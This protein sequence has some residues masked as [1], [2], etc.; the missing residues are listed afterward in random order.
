VAFVLFFI[1]LGIPIIE[2]AL[3]I[4]VGGA[5]GLFPT[6]AI[7]VLTA[8]VGSAMI[9]AQGLRTWMQAR[10]SMDRGE[11]PVRELFD[12]LCIFAAGI[13]LVTPGFFTDA[14]GFLL[15]LPPIRHIL[16]ERLVRSMVVVQGG[17]MDAQA[18]DRTVIIETEFHE[19]SEDDRENGPERRD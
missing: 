3:F 13:M 16:A 17:R 11:M 15:L 6:L 12:G 2:I 5:I 18:P 7:V 10:A 1:L 8:L 19:V 9:R 4:K 14:M